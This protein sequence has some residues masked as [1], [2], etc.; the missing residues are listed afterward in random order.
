MPL[1]RHVLTILAVL[2]PLVVYGQSGSVIGQITD[3]ASGEALPGATVAVRGTALGAATDVEGEYWMRSVPSGNRT[4]T[5]SYVGY[6]SIDTVVAVPAGGSLRLNMALRSAVLRGDEVVITAQLEGQQKAI[7]QQLSSNTIVNVVSAERIQEL[8]DRNAAESLQRLPGIAVERNAGEGQKVIIRGLSPKFNSITVNGERI[9]STDP[10]DRSVDLSMIS[11]EMLAGIEVFKSLTPDKDGDAV[12]GTVNFV[13]A[14]ARPDWHGNL[15]LQGGYSDHVGGVENFK[16]SASFSNRFLDSRLG[17]LITGNVERADRSSDVL[18]GN[19]SFQRSQSEG[20]EIGVHRVEN[21]NLVHRVETRYRGGGSL[22]ADYRLDNGSILLSSF[23]SSTSRDELRRRRRYRLSAAYTEYDYRERDVAV[24]L[25]TNSLSG[26]HNFSA[27]QLTWR[28]SFS[29]TVT[30]VPREFNGRFRELAAFKSDL[31][32]TEGPDLIPE[33]AKKNLDATWF[34]EMGFDST[35]VD[36]RDLTAQADLKFPIR[37]GNSVAGHVKLGAKHRDKDRNRDKSRWWSDHFGIN[38]IGAEYRENPEAFYRDFELDIS[39]R[40]L[41]SNFTTDVDTVGSEFLDGRFEFGPTLDM[42]ELLFFAETFEDRFIPEPTAI[43]EVYTAGE[44]ISAGYLMAELNLGPRVMILPGVRYEFTSTAYTSVFGRPGSSDDGQS[45]VVGRRDTTGGQDYGEWLPMFHLRVKPA[46]WF[47]VRLAATRTLS[48]PDYFNLVPWERIIFFE[49]EVERG[50][51]EL[52]HATAW[53]YDAYLSF[54][55]RWGLFTVGG[56]YKQVWD[57]DYIRSSRITEGE[58]SGFMLTEP[59]NALGRSEV[60]G[61]EF[62]IQTNL[63]WLPSPF[64]GIVLFMNYALI[65]SETPYPLLVVGPRSPDPPFL[66]TFIDT[67]RTGKMP[68]QADYLANAAI[69]YE[70]NGF[71]G[72]LSVVFQGES[73]QFVGTREELDGFTASFA[74]WDLTVQQKLAA[75]LSLFGNVNNFTNRPEGA[76]LALEAFPTREEFFGWSADL[77]VRFTF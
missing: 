63:S 44:A 26:K 42:E 77:G 14:E 71:S 50:N 27:A 46:D 54:Y 67:V 76:F 38:E 62:D 24:S 16:G 21:M 70:K 59:E 11:P 6:T 72:R 5:F 20:Q 74:R 15:R 25:W 4:I 75:G 58:L 47:D 23:L 18:D 3:A 52:R 65:D 31:I 34:K 61:V 2:L 49:S 64:D 37:L 45:G 32:D 12:G 60:I 22:T 28:G 17:V 53:N 56:F 41:I 40:I 29:K 39:R 55:N 69:G 19:Y 43:L 35:K 33:G 8:P 48:R 10:N 36:D 51:S 68:G 7:N 30:D 9:P 57:I 13:I 66:P 1:V 73:L